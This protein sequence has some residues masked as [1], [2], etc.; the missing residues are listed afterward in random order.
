MPPQQPTEAPV[1]LNDQGEPTYLDDNGDPQSSAAA[2]VNKEPS[3]KDKASQFIAG[4]PVLQRFLFGPSE[5]DLGGVPLL[6]KPTDESLLPRMEHPSDEGWPG[7]IARG[8]YNQVVRPLGSPEGLIGAAAPKIPIAKG[9]IASEEAIQSGL[10]KIKP[11]VVEPPAP[12]PIPKQLASGPRFISGRAG[13]A[14]VTTP[15]HI[16]MGP[17]KEFQREATILPH[18]FGE[19][20]PLTPEMAAESGTSLGQPEIVPKPGEPTQAFSEGQVTDV[21]NTPRPYEGTPLTDAELRR[22]IRPSKEEVASAAKNTGVIPEKLA[23]ASEMAPPPIKEAIDQIV[24]EE[25]PRKSKWG[26]IY[27]RLKPLP[28][29]DELYARS[30]RAVHTERQLR[31]EWTPQL[32]EA[33][34]KLSKLDKQNFGAYAEGKIPITD[35]RV[36]D[37]VNIWKATEQAIG[38][39]AENVQLRLFPESQ[40]WIPF[41]KHPGD[42]WPHIID[43]SRD[44]QKDLAEKLMKSGMTRNE[45]QRVINHWRNTGEIVIGPQ[46]A[47]RLGHNLDYRLDADVALQHVRSMAKRIAQHIEFGPRDVNGKGTEGISDLIE[48]GTKDERNLKLDLM[49]RIIGRNQQQDQKLTK[50]LNMARKYSMITKLQNFSLPNV[51]LGQTVNA[52]KASPYPVESFKEISKLV[53]RR[54]RD[55]LRAS[56]I[57]QDFAH[58][59]MDEIPLTGRDWY[60][61]GAG[62]A[63]N[64]SIAGSIG[65]GVA[66]GAFKTLKSDSTDKLARNELFELLGEDVNKVVQQEDLSDT[67]LRMAA[68]RMAE[69]TQG[70]NVPGNLPYSWS[71]PVKDLPTFAYQLGLIFKKMGYQATRSVWESVK[72]NPARAIPIWLA[73]A[74]IGGELIGDSKAFLRGIYTG[75]PSDIIEDRGSYWLQNAGIPQSAIETASELSGV[76]P[77]VIARLFDNYNQA[78]FLGLPA[79]M[80]MSSAYGPEGLVKYFGGPVVGDVSSLANRIYREDYKGMAKDAISSLPLPGSRGLADYLFSEP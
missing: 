51:L 24:K 48:T 4:H 57:M 71:S 58:S 69:R 6:G 2:P 73:A 77:S 75:D 3:I 41:Q 49:K 9:T 35:Q 19:R 22:P 56:G 30:F 20:N 28:S 34:N 61:I 54:Y 14:D 38:D 72:T 36:Q 70:L 27:T 66:R 11:P 60:G 7:Y 15:Y 23:E 39:K 65:R 25:A 47:R 79:D 29:G 52:V 62:E 32:E 78:F 55:E 12:K 67:Q 44:T 1:Y 80:L 53:G 64:R 43:Y 8:L 33:I 13:T 68:G 40:K 74:G 17:V 10:S 76:D 16:D 59:L 63:V 21:P 31:S 5:E 42:Y 46:H 50:V 45:A 37:A 18:E 26:A